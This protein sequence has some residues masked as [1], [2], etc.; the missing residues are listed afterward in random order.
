VEL[1]QQQQQQQ[2]QDWEE[3]V[4]NGLDIG[5]ITELGDHFNWRRRLFRVRNRA[6]QLYSLDPVSLMIEII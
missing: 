5:Y 3:L 2:Q 1:L 4:P 6:L